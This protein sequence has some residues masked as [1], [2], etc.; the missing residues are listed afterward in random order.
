M[1]LDREYPD[2]PSP[3]RVLMSWINPFG[4]PMLVPTIQSILM[5]SVSLQ[6]GGLTHEADLM[7]ELPQA[8]YKLLDWHSFDDIVETGYR[9]AVP[10]IERWQ[11][12]KSDSTAAV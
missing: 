1:R 9:M 11:S 7:F 8:G 12:Q 6:S 2:L 3:W 10:I 5:R 4:T